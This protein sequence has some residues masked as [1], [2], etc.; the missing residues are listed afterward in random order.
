MLWYWKLSKHNWQKILVVLYTNLSLV[1]VQDKSHSA[2]CVRR[3]LQPI[4]LCIFSSLQT[5]TRTW[6]DLSTPSVHVDRFGQMDSRW[7]KDGQIGQTI[8]APAWCRQ[9]PG[10]LSSLIGVGQYFNFN[11]N[12]YPHYSEK[13]ASPFWKNLLPIGMIDLHWSHCTVST[14]RSQPNSVIFVS[15]GHMSVSVYEY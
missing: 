11:V 6:S 14:G 12:W 4:S 5:E 13:V 9:W 7:W 10:I 15:Q 1:D 2:V 8:P 3:N